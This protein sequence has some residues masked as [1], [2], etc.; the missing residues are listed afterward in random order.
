MYSAYNNFYFKRS[1]RNHNSSNTVKSKMM[2]MKVCYT[3]ALNPEIQDTQLKKLAT[4]LVNLIV[5]FKW[6]TQSSV[7]Y[8]VFLK[9]KP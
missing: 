6:F 5:E 7:L 3:I 4:V 8:V 9:E 2:D 1:F